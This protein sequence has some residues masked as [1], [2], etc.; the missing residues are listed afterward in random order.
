V[1]NVFNGIQSAFTLGPATN[2]ATQFT[3]FFY[4]SSLAESNYHAAFMSYHIRAYH[5]LILD[6]N[7]TYGHSLDSV[8]VN[9]DSD[10][11]FSNSYDPHYDY[12]TS[13]FDRKYVLT[14]LGVW[15]LPFRSQTGWVKQVIG[16]WQLSPILSVASGLPL[17][18]LDGSGQEFGQASF[19][20]GSEAIR[21]GS[22]GA[23]AGIHRVAPTTGA[24]SSASGKGSGLNIF[25][26]PQAVLNQFRPIQLSVDTTSR[27]GTLRGLRNW[28]LDLSLAK[29]IFLSE[30]ARLTFSAEFF[31]TFNHVNFLDPAVNLQSQQTFGV[32]TTQGNDPR[33]IQ[34]GLR[35]DF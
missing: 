5:G 9:Q 19:G 11:S 4:W 1:R 10:Q 14:V 15:E 3:N 29:K 22:G 35:F 25:A 18:V 23:N 20:F 34:L 21:I 7:F 12:G 17:R 28:N 32:I 13:V 6:A 33:Q 27:G 26:D 16:G 2:A 8:T 30:R 31:N 24:G